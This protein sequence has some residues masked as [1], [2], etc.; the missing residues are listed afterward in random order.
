MMIISRFILK[1]RRSVQESECAALTSVRFTQ[2]QDGTV[3]IAGLTDDMGQPLAHGFS[4]SNPVVSGGVSQADVETASA[5][6][7]PA[8][9]DIVH[10]SPEPE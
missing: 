1:L 9:A 3:T 4:I 2:S 6:P 8:S 7:A 10:A 5:T